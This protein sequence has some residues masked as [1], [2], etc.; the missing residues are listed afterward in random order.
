[1]TS[2][3]QRVYAE[4]GISP[5]ILSDAEVQDARN[6]LI[7][8]VLPGEK[9]AAAVQDSVSLST[10]AAP[11]KATVTEPASNT[12]PT[13]KATDTGH[14]VKDDDS[15]ATAAVVSE[16]SQEDGEASETTN[17]EPTVRRRRRRR[18]SAS[19]DS[20]EE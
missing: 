10:P 6:S 7:S 2:D 4:M 11:I 13:P 3:E 1:M 5:L 9:S 15:S 12:K 18:S 16:T 8:V 20:S 19:T 17:E 14:P